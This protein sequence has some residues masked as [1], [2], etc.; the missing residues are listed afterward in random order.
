MPLMMLY[1]QG[2]S[3]KRASGRLSGTGGCG[4]HM[5]GV[6]GMERW[7]LYFQMCLREGTCDCRDPRSRF[8]MV[9]TPDSLPSLVQVPYLGSTTSSVAAQVGRG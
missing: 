8:S 7:E 2:P 1:T 3:E 5:P 4:S 6:K 9:C